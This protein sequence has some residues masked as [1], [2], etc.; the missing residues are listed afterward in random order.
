MAAWGVGLFQNDIGPEIKEEYIRNLKSGKTDIQAYTDAVN[1]F[2]YAESLE[3]DKVDLWLALASVMFDYGRLDDE[4]RTKALS[5]ID[6][7]ADLDR[8]EGKDLSKRV[9][10]LENLRMKLSSPM[11]ERKAVSVY[12]R[13][14]PKVSPNDIYYFE[15]EGYES[16]YAIILV[17]SWYKYDMRMKGL[18]DEFPVVYL[19]LSSFLPERIS[20][21]DSL[22]FANMRYGD[23]DSDQRVLL[24]PNG[25]SGVKKKL[26]LWG[27]Y[28]FARP[29]DSNVHEI[30]DYSIN[31]CLTYS[32][33]WKYL[34][35]QIKD[36]LWNPQF[37]EFVN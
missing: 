23:K 30:T 31:H 2:A 1:E 17:D 35:H 28:D 14:V 19:K 11:P 33:P 20:D 3:D 27:N 5:L 37:Q 4:V 15:V 16:L 26:H 24:M 18:G 13:F 32:T 8:W 10:V 29:S 34:E 7:S 36:Y 6:V 22:K 21:V 9:K 12:R 25:F